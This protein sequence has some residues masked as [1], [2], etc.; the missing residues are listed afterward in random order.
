MQLPCGGFW[1]NVIRTFASNREIG[2][3]GRL[4]DNS[5][6]EIIEDVL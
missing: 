6:Q 4:F 3:D 5:G 2:R 1:P